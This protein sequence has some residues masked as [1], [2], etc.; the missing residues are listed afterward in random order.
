MVPNLVHGLVKCMSTLQQCCIYMV[1]QT[2][3]SA[4][5]GKKHYATIPRAFIQEV[6]QYFAIMLNVYYFI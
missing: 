3:V 1:S 6:F 5:L 4:I 2:S